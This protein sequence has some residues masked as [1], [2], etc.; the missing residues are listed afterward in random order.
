M[1]TD[2]F[3]PDDRETSRCRESNQAGR[4][5]LHRGYPG[6]LSVTAAAGNVA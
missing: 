1:W 6:R 2:S 5:S 4:M 3:V